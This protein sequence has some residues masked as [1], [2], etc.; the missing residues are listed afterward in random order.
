MAK[1][2]KSEQKWSF[3]HLPVLDQGY[4]ASLLEYGKSG[5]RTGSRTG[6]KSGPRSG[7]ER[8]PERGPGRCTQGGVL[9]AG[10]YPGPVHLP[11]LPYPGTLLHHPGTPCTPL[12]QARLPVLRV[13]RCVP[14]GDTL[15]SEALRSLGGFL[16]RDYPAQSCYSFF[17][18]NHREARGAEERESDKIG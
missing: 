14:G 16:L 12:V 8:G 7:P 9:W 6:S 5:L 1:V 11:T 3:W 2:C 4:T 10:Y 18:R 15:G 17:E 13:L